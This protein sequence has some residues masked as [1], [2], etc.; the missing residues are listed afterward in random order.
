MAQRDPPD[1][2]KVARA[3]VPPNRKLRRMLAL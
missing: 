1:V 3:A 2:N